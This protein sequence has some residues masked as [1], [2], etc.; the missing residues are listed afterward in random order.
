MLL[1][2]NYEPTN[3]QTQ[4]ESLWLYLSIYHQ[5]GR[6]AFDSYISCMQCRGLLVVGVGLRRKGDSSE[7]VSLESDAQRQVVVQVLNR[8]CSLRRFSDHIQRSKAS[9]SSMIV[10]SYSALLLFWKMQS[11]V[12]IRRHRFDLQDY[13]T[14]P[15]LDI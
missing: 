14:T 13:I 7:L 4:G 5:S 11:I 2:A 15:D 3:L 8:W 1:Y 10:R 6:I 12:A 9:Y